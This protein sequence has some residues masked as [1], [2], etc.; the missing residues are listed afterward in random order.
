MPETDDLIVALSGLRPGDALLETVA[1]RADILSLS[2]LTHDAALLPSDPG[3]LSHAER[4][5]LATRI[6]QRNQDAEFVAHFSKLLAR[7]GADAATA[8]LADI[9][10]DGGDDARLAALARHTDLVA[11]SPRDATGADIDRLKVAGIAEADIVRLSELIAF[12]SYQIR[13]A[14]G[15]RLMRGLA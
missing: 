3:G 8:R 13:V 5:A 2:Q 6:A 4:A 15:L 9:S 1:G 14:A 11:A 10:F 7:S 12:V